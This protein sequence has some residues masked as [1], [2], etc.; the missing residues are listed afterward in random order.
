MKPIGLLLL[1]VVL[2]AGSVW[3]QNKV[4]SLDG[5]GD[6]VE[7]PKITFSYQALT[8]EAWVKSKSEGNQEIIGTPVDPADNMGAGIQL[9]IFDGGILFDSINVLQ[10]RLT[11][12]KINLLE[13]WHHISAVYGE[14]GTAIYVDGNKL[15]NQ[16]KQN[17]IENLQLD[18]SD[19]IFRIGCEVNTDGQFWNGALD[20]IRIWNVARTKDEILA[21]M[22][23]PLTGN[24]NGLVGYWNFDDGTANDL[25]AN[26]N[27]GEFKGDAKVVDSDL[28]LGVSIPDSNLRAALEKALG[29][30]EEIGRAS[31]RERV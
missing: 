22:N 16:D 21:S 14:F 18:F 26:G 6:Y 8:V 27:D 7:I 24:E 30:N 17:D 23:S 28:A 10:G 9:E 25:T 2:A 13:K 29:K 15:A 12:P 1:L 5:D 20:E 19:A 11:S 3:A 31:C 4:L